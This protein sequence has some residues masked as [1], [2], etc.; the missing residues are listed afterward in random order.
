MYWAS[1]GIGGSCGAREKSGGVETGR[2]RTE[3]AAPFAALSSGAV[4]QQW[5]ASSCGAGSRENAGREAAHAALAAGVVHTG[6]C[7]Q[8]R[9]AAAALTAAAAAAAAAAVAR[10]LQLEPLSSALSPGRLLAAGC[11]SRR[12]GCPAPPSARAW[13]R[14]RSARSSTCG[15][16]W[17][18]T[19]RRL[20]CRRRRRRTARRRGR[21]CSRSRTA[22]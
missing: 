12:R 4:K 17:C 15:R 21:R 6:G 8:V 2:C 3:A 19:A 9:A 7:V 10:V 20:T 14:T 1:V 13:W 18:S 5:V 22:G 11:R 16:S